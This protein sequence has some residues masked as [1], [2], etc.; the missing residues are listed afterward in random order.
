MGMR[1]KWGIYS[2]RA[3]AATATTDASQDGLSCVQSTFCRHAA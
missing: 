1:G 3:E 2:Y